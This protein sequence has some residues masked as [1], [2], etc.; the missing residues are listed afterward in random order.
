MFQM[1]YFPLR[2]KKGTFDLPRVAKDILR[3]LLFVFVLVHVHT[4]L[5]SK[6]DLLEI[7]PTPL[8]YDALFHC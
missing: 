1:M 5:G 7:P 4:Y 2:K 3:S 6:I 8:N